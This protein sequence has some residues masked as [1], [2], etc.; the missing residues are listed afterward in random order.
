M[1]PAAAAGLAVLA[2]ADFLAP[3]YDDGGEPNTGSFDDT[4][5]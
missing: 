5:L 3:A 4:G 2:F 1:K